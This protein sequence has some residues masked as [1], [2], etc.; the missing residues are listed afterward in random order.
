MSKTLWLRRM[1][2]VCGILGGLL[3]FIAI[4]SVLL[5]KGRPEHSL[6]SISATYYLSPALPAI[7]TA[8]SICLMT[9]DGYSLL[10][11][12]I[13]TAT[14]IFGLGIV[15]FPCSVGWLDSFDKVG[16]FQIPMHYSNYIHCGCAAVFFVLLSFNC[17]FLFTRTD[18]FD[19][20]TE[21]KKKRNVIYRACAVVM[22]CFELWQVI[23]VNFG[24]AG[25]WTM[26][27][28]IG[29]LLAFCLAWIT[30]GG[31]VLKD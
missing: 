20:V 3:P 31:L 5:I 10:D 16:F 17:W 27:T 30:K 1:R 28:E 14:G 22:L 7:L 9:Y 15:M 19:T 8:A 29:L 13:T 11:D 4:F 26:V 2:N 18:D 21:N 12:I 25:W 6:Y 24:F 23:T